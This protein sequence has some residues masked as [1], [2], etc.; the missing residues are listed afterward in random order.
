[1]SS[2]RKRMVYETDAGRHN[3]KY[4]KRAAKDATKLSE[5]ETTVSHCCALSL[6]FS[7]QGSQTVEAACGLD[8]GF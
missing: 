2:M 4:G 6:F 7:R 1:M 3:D 8:C 5:E